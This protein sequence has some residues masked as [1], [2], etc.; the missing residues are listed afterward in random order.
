MPSLLDGFVPLS[1]MPQLP[2]NLTLLGI[3]SRQRPVSGHHVPHPPLLFGTWHKSW[4]IR[5]VCNIEIVQSIGRLVAERERERE[6]KRVSKCW[7][8]E[9]REEML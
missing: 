2:D 5:H 9:W 7:V 6:R 4:H 8:A 3:L 1:V